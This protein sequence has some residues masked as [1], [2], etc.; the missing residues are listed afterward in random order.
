MYSQIQINLYL[1]YFYIWALVQLWIHSRVEESFPPILLC[2]PWLGGNVIY[3]ALSALN[4]TVSAHNP[5]HNPNR[6]LSSSMHFAWG[7]CGPSPRCHWMNFIWCYV[8]PTVHSPSRLR[9]PCLLCRKVVLGCDFFRKYADTQICIRTGR[10]L[11]FQMLVTVFRWC[12][13]II[14]CFFCDFIVTQSLE[15][16]IIFSNSQF[17]WIHFFEENVTESVGPVPFSPQW[18]W[19]IKCGPWKRG[20]KGNSHVQLCQQK[21]TRTLTVIVHINHSMMTF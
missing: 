12:L 1:L 21:N 2:M 8:I 15:S 11:Y 6:I 4:K 5:Q 16:L 18:S 19:G 7:A 9:L 13:M 10:N 20:W 17:T 3:G 14:S